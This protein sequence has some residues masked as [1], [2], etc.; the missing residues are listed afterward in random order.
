M[1]AEGVMQG[2]LQFTVASSWV[3]RATVVH[4]SRLGVYVYRFG[5]GKDGWMYGKFMYIGIWMDGNHQ[6]TRSLE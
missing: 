6:L 2:L 5:R 4:G 1:V 3:L